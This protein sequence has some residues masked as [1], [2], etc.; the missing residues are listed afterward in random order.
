M[1]DAE[2]WDAPLAEN[3]MSAG[4]TPRNVQSGVAELGAYASFGGCGESGAGYI[5]APSGA[6]DCTGCGEPI[7]TYEACAAAAALRAA[8]MGVGGL[9]GSE[10]W[11]GPP[12]CHV[13]DGSNFQFNSNMDGGAWEGHTPICAADAGGGTRGGSSSPVVC[14]HSWWR[15]VHSGEPA[16]DACSRDISNTVSPKVTGWPA[17]GYD[18]PTVPVR[19]APFKLDYPDDRP[20]GP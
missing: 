19:A 15:R 12:G 7:L 10:F 11:D 17:T 20:W 13:Q 1:T 16:S 6:A 14:D 9:G 5:L 3:M 2:D 4:R 18:D 8:A